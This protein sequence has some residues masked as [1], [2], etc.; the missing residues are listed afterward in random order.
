VLRSAKALG[1]ATA[2]DLADYFALH[3]ARVRR[4]VAELVSAGALEPVEVEGWDDAAYVTSGTGTPPT[5]DHAT[6]L[7]SPFDS[8]VFDRARTERVFDF[9]YRLEMYVSAARRTYGYYVL[10]FLFGDRLAARVDVKADRPSRAL[11]AK[12]VWLE[13][14]VDGAAVLEAVRA[15][16]ERMAAWLGLDEVVHAGEPQWNDG[17]PAPAGSQLRLL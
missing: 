15:A 4:H 13:A 6:A 1:V 14:G 11:H 5:V 12:G 10:P 7:L 8:L 17:G 16:L 9:R 3:K 2:P